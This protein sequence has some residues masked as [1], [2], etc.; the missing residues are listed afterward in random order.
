M[1]YSKIK[2]DEKSELYVLEKIREF[3]KYWSK[4]EEVHGFNVYCSRH[5][6]RSYI[7]AKNQFALEP[8]AVLD[9]PMDYAN[10]VKRPLIVNAISYGMTGVK[11][12]PAQVLEDEMVCKH[13][14]SIGDMSGLI[15]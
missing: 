9:F 8:V 12:L 2:N 5:P 14:E 15:H 10:P 3:T 1:K 13:N 4:F 6:E 11:E 7:L